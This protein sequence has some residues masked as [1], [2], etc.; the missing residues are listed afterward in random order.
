MACSGDLE[1]QVCEVE[2]LFI[3]KPWGVSA[4]EV[5]EHTGIS[6]PDDKPGKL[7]GEIIWT[8]SSP[9]EASGKTDSVSSNQLKDCN[10]TL[11][12]VV[13]E[14]G[15]S[16]VGENIKNFRRLRGKTECWHVEKVEGWVDVVTGLKPAVT[17][18]R[19]VELVGR[20]FF[21]NPAGLPLTEFLKKLEDVLEFTPLSE[22]DT[23]ILKPGTLH[24]IVPREKESIAVIS[25]TQEGFGSNL[26]PML[27]KTLFLGDLT[28]LQV[29]PSREQAEK[30]ISSEDEV[31]IRQVLEEPTFRVSDFG[32]GRA[33]FP[34]EST[35][36]LAFGEITC[37]KTSPITE[38][39]TEGVSATHLCANRFFA[40]DLVSVSGGSVFESWFPGGSYVVLNVAEG[41]GELISGGG[42]LPLARGSALVLA[43][44]LG[45]CT[46]SAREDMR[47]YWEHVP[48]LIKLADH[49]RGVGFSREEIMG[50]DGT[51]TGN[52]FQSVFS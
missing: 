21:E 4:D 19:Y 14:G 1:Y 10:T 5:R 51:C 43:A 50:L 11:A 23:Y 3:E 37:S 30:I 8:A 49:L 29:H 40:K 28:S 26:L 52:D 27:Q 2:P 35:D 6:P 39:L 38:D 25:E 7:W 47:F 20:G 46:V 18:E 33:V 16:F 45:G 48:D 31:L 24:T 15:V 9:K 32:R 34:G 41:S 12:E 22:G 44:G 17:R 42:S 13:G 36:L